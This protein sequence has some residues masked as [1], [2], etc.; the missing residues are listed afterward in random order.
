MNGAFT[1]S[2]TVSDSVS[3]RLH[4]LCCGSLGS[5]NLRE[6]IV[7]HARVQSSTEELSMRVSVSHLRSQ[8]RYVST[9]EPLP[10]PSPIPHQHI[11]LLSIQFFL[12]AMKF[13]IFLLLSPLIFITRLSRK[14]FLHEL[15]LLQIH[16]N[17]FL[18]PT[19]QPFKSH[20]VLDLHPS[21]AANT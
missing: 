5:S 15:H 18:I 14:Q 17:F 6:N 13:L 21:Q 16:S 20:P 19:Y 12:R 8:M 9:K 2:M 4:V 11:I 7:K 10:N 1:Q 3:V